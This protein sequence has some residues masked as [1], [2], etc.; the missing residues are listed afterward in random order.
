MTYS[1][2]LTAVIAQHP[3]LDSAPV[4]EWLQKVFWTLSAHGE[5]LVLATQGA[6]NVATVTRRLRV[7]EDL[8]WIVRGKR[9]PTRQQM[10][11]DASNSIKGDRRG[12]HT[13]VYNWM[14]N[15]DCA[16][17]QELTGAIPGFVAQLRAGKTYKQLQEEARQARTSPKPAPK[18]NQN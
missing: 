6:D 7:M 1:P 11:F 12:F 15:Q 14:P 9:E 8:G 18:P 2:S 5:T 17:A 16:D 13:E 10:F 4:R 3:W